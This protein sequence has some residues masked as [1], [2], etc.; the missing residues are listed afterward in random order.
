MKRILILG[1]LLLPCWAQA[2]QNAAAPVSVPA[3]LTAVDRNG[4]RAEV[5]EFGDA[6]FGESVTHGFTLRNDGATPVALSRV[7]LSCGCLSTPLASQPGKPL[8]T[9]LPGA[10]LRVDVT[11]DTGRLPE[12]V[13]APLFAGGQV[14]K[15]VLIY[16]AG[17]PVHA[18][19]VLTLRGRI[20]SGVQIQ[21]ATLNFGSVR[22]SEGASRIARVVYD[23]A[24]F[25][26]G[27][28]RLAAPKNSLLRV[29]ALPPQSSPPETPPDGSRTATRPTVARSY[30]VTLPPHTPL[31]AWSGQLRVEGLAARTLPL[32]HSNGKT[33][34]PAL[35]RRLPCLAQIQ[36]SVR[37][38]PAL[39][40]FGLVALPRHSKPD[41][42]PDRQQRTRWILLQRD[43][44]PSSAPPSAS[45]S[46]NN[47]DAFW[48]GATAQVD[49]A[50]FQAALVSPLPSGNAAP[51]SPQTVSP[52]PLAVGVRPETVCWLRL[53][54]LPD[55][56]RGKSLSVRVTVTLPNGEQLNVPLLAQTQ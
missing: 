38:L 26:E 24:L 25:R 21:P 16:A 22:A 40:A 2:G 49:G 55:A 29:T 32:P 4:T 10:S 34:V 27:H 8:P 48:K 19:L 47:S 28:T 30:R 5:Y 9:L 53:T 6:L 36:G 17:Q 15:Q 20:V 13:N 31:G 52:P 50:H 1:G 42:L 18:A 12:A 43:L 46:A 14:E 23:A 11:L 33:P 45:G 56:P 54:L 39:A 41:S 7:T 35:T 3:R 51:P 44:P 37:A